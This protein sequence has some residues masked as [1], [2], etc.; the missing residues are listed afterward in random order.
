MFAERGKPVALAATVY[1]TWPSVDWGVV[2]ESTVSQSATA[3]LS[4]VQVPLVPGPV[5]VTSKVPDPPATGTSALAGT[6]MTGGTSGSG[7]PGS[8]GSRR[9]IGRQELPMLASVA[10]SRTSIGGRFTL[11]IS[12][13]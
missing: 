8:S 1:V 11:Y 6:S 3:S 9:S 7:P 10:A 5:I 13:G 2:G 4:T 12:L